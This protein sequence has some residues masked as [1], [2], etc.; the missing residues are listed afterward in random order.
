M[1]ILAIVFAVIF[2]FFFK[3]LLFQYILSARSRSNAVSWQ[4]GGYFTGVNIFITTGLIRRILV[5]IAFFIL[6]GGKTRGNSYFYLYLC[7]VVLYFLLMGNDIFAYRASLCFDIFAI[8]MFGNAVI[9]KSYTNVFVCVGLFLLL[10][11]TYISP[12]KGY[13]VPYTT[14]LPL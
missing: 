11:V 2:R 3:D 7:G 13:V 8:P 1:I 9:K 5:A 6:S 4:L 12:L 10:L 14:Y